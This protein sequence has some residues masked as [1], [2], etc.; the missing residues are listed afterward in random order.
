[1][2]S[3]QLLQ[4]AS[5][6]SRKPLKETHRE[7]CESNLRVSAPL[8]R[9]FSP[10]A[11]LLSNNYHRPSKATL[12]QRYCQTRAKDIFD[13]NSV[14][15][16]PNHSLDRDLMLDKRNTASTPNPRSTTSSPFS[17]IS[18][19]SQKATSDHGSSH[20]WDEVSDLDLGVRSVSSSDSEGSVSEDLNGNT[21]AYAPDMASGTRPESDDGV[22]SLTS[23]DGVISLGSEDGAASLGSDVDGLSLVSDSVQVQNDR[24]SASV[25][26][27]Q[28]LSKENTEVL[29]KSEKSTEVLDK[30]EFPHIW[31]YLNGL[32]PGSPPLEPMTLAVPG[33]PHEG[34][35]QPA[36]NFGVPGPD[37]QSPPSLSGLTAGLAGNTDEVMPTEEPFVIKPGLARLLQRPGIYMVVDEKAHEKPEASRSEHAALAPKS[38]AP[39][40]EYSDIAE[41]VPPGEEPL[42]MN[43]GLARMLKG[44]LAM[45]LP[46]ASSRTPSPSPSPSPPSLPVPLGQTVTAPEHRLS[47]SFPPGHRFY[48]KSKEEIDEALVQIQLEQPTVR[49]L[50]A[51]VAKLKQKSRRLKSQVAELEKTVLDIRRENEVFRER[52]QE[53]YAIMTEDDYE[54]S[55]LRN[56]I[57]ELT[58]YNETVGKALIVLKEEKDS[59]TSQKRELEASNIALT[60]QRSELAAQREAIRQE[61]NRKFAQVKHENNSLKADNARL[62]DSLQILRERYSDLAAENLE[63]NAGLAARIRNI[64]GAMRSKDAIRFSKEDVTVQDKKKREL[65]LDDIRDKVVAPPPLSLEG[66]DQLVSDIRLVNSQEFED[67]DR[68][69]ACVSEPASSADSSSEFSIE[70]YRRNRRASRYSDGWRYGGCESCGWGNTTVGSQFLDSEGYILDEDAMWHEKAVKKREKM[71][72]EELGWG[73]WGPVN[74]HPQ[75]YADFRSGSR[76]KKR[77]KER[78]VKKWRKDNYWLLNRH[79][80]RDGYE[81]PKKCNR[82]GNRKPKKERHQKVIEEVMETHNSEHGLDAYSGEIL[83]MSTAVHTNYTRDFEAD[84]VGGVFC[85]RNNLDKSTSWG[86]SRFYEDCTHWMHYE[87]RNEDRCDKIEN[88]LQNGTSSSCDI[89]WNR[90]AWDH[91]PGYIRKQ[92]IDEG[93]DLF[94]VAGCFN[95]QDNGANHIHQRECEEQEQKPPFAP[96]LPEMLN[97]PVYWY[98]RRDGTWEFS[99]TRQF[100]PDPKPQNTDRWDYESEYYFGDYYCCDLCHLAQSYDPYM[101]ELLDGISIASWPCPDEDEYG[102]EEQWNVVYED[103]YID[104]SMDPG[105]QGGDF[106][107]K[108]ADKKRWKKGLEKRKRQEKIGRKKGSKSGPGKKPVR[109]QG[110]M[111][112]RGR[113]LIKHDNEDASAWFEHVYKESADKFEITGM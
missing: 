31:S 39:A 70:T 63:R 81:R 104:A 68:E 100:A 14:D 6:T 98:H 83:D 27:E 47:V 18:N 78:R 74:E 91:P 50:E 20:S 46:L 109:R 21:E 93:Y 96:G 30:R 4:L 103:L 16:R 8:K 66:Y 2:N 35:G 76:D 55:I 87:S 106:R 37:T 32:E 51:K 65:I 89:F 88:D 40:S 22:I 36:W 72:G 12:R 95:S 24:L 29:G 73:L 75:E 42:I 67:N 57:N 15:L 94:I 62:S 101:A 110:K 86:Y 60:T 92:F 80:T 49:G 41:A 10:L 59:L 38:N 102:P 34:H 108:A 7:S 28:V 26:S 77:D 64:V 52:S 111:S 25:D 3:K 82:K 48:G 84:L 19:V 17:L 58:A 113:L 90:D 9:C 54:K 44:G 97:N 85:Y 5:G 1:M 105:I 45:D 13:S 61:S 53:D 71:V 33:S 56:S 11:L 79:T 69:P 99:I 43:P 112:G 23:Y 107:G